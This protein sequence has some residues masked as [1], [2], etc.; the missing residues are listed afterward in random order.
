MKQS[1]GEKRAIKAKKLF[2][3]SEFRRVATK[4]RLKKLICS[5]E[6]QSYLLEKLTNDMPASL[7][8]NLL[9]I[10]QHEILPS[11][12]LAEEGLETVRTK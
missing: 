4:Q 2:E 11:I 7:E 8:R 10:L 3:D 6:D 1:L 5:L 12:K 9:S